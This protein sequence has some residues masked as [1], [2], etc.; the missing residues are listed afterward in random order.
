MVPASIPDT[1]IGEMPSRSALSGWLPSVRGSNVHL[2]PR[3]PAAM[4]VSTPA[5]LVSGLVI[6]GPVGQR[7]ARLATQF[8]ATFSL[9]KVSAERY[10]R[11]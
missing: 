1:C 8:V 6:V 2:C 10:A 11:T 9:L 5:A 3:S 7:L 4:Q